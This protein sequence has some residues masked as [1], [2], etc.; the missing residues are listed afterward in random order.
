MGRER[1]QRCFEGTGSVTNYA[2]AQCNVTHATRD[3]GPPGQWLSVGRLG[4][5]EG[6][7][8]STEQVTATWRCADS[9]MPAPA[10]PC[11]SPRPVRSQDT[12][13]QFVFDCDSFWPPKVDADC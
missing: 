10:M 1:G 4:A 3:R 5:A 7:T 2:G 8:R 11:H 13:G 12:K 6:E 9:R